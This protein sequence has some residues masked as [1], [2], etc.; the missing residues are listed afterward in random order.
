[1]KTV[2]HVIRLSV[3][4]WNFCNNFYKDD[5]QFIPSSARKPIR[6]TIIGRDVTMWTHLTGRI[7]TMAGVLTYSDELPC[8]TGGKSS[9][10]LSVILT[11][12]QMSMALFVATSLSLT[13]RIL[14][15]MTMKRMTKRGLTQQKC[16][17]NGLRPQTFISH[18][19]FTYWC[20]FAS[21]LISMLHW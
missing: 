14:A 16:A 20:F 12:F 21:R 11:T 9:A 15:K 6:S 10:D 18:Y 19:V 13:R 5:S 8:D 1:M 3:F 4:E 17:E 2:C 7:F